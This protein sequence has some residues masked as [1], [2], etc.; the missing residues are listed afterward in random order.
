MLA[1]LTEAN[2]VG[3]QP[4]PKYFICISELSYELV[5]KTFVMQG[6]AKQETCSHFFHHNSVVFPQKEIL[7]KHPPFSHL[8]ANGQVVLRAFIN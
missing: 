4:K 6:S 1:T 7:I 2:R 3:K 8:P 5:K